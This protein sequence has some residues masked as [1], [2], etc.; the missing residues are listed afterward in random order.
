MAFIGDKLDEFAR[1]KPERTALICG[2][3]RVN[4]QT[5]VQNIAAAELSEA[6]SLPQVFEPEA[7]SD[8]H[9]PVQ[10]WVDGACVP[11][12]DGSLHIGWAFLVNVD[13]QDAVQALFAHASEENAAF[14]HQHQVTHH[15]GHHLC[16]KDHDRIQKRFNHL[17][18]P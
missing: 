4:W 6:Q 8:A 15:T 12:A 1:S 2:E 5:L 13:G 17:V 10:V 7:S 9:S 16:N 11:A 18:G 14:M 3:I